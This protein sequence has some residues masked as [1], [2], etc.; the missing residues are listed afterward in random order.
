[1]GAR[2]ESTDPRPIMEHLKFLGATSYWLTKNAS[3][4]DATVTGLA[5][6]AMTAEEHKGESALFATYKPENTLADLGKDFV[7]V[8]AYLH[9]LTAWVATWTTPRGVMKGLDG[10]VLEF[11]A[12][13]SKLLTEDAAASG[14]AGRRAGTMP[15]QSAFGGLGLESNLTA[16][17][18]NLAPAAG[19]QAILESRF[20]AV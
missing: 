13:L 3:V 7:G 4:M 5:K 8:Q 2:D 10:K 11:E 14:T 1:M 20:K 15:L 16:G 19:N 9:P 18:N 17:V 12:R 6:V